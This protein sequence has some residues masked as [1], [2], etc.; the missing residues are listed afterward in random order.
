MN[1]APSTF[2]SRFLQSRIVWPLAGLAL[3]LLFNFAFDRSFFDLTT[4]DGNLYG[5]MVTV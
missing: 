5:P 2:V 3:L 1:N 4:L